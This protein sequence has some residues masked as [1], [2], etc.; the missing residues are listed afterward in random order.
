MVVSQLS[1]YIDITMMICGN[2]EL[3]CVFRLLY[4]DAIMLHCDITN[5]QFVIIVLNC[6][7]T[8]IHCAI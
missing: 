2:M 4:Y 6:D 3:Q 5:L 1:F 8:K 7:I